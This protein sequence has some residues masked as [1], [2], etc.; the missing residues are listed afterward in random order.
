MPEERRPEYLNVAYITRR[1]GIPRTAISD[2]I[3]NGKLEAFRIRRR[4]YVLNHKFD[5]WMRDHQVEP[6]EL[7]N[8]S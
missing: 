6:E 8:A 1:Y 7:S 3:K 2:A 5:D 4:L